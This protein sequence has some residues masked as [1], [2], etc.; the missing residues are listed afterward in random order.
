MRP[1]RRHHGHRGS[2]E[3]ADVRG[4]QGH[5][6]ADQRRRCAR[7]ARARGGRS[8]AGGGAAV[9]GSLGRSRSLGGTWGTRSA[10]P[11][12]GLR[13]PPPPP[14]PSPSPL[15]GPR[16]GPAPARRG[17]AYVPPITASASGPPGVCPR[18]RPWPDRVL[19]PAAAPADPRPSPHPFPVARLRSTISWRPS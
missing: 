3:A 19:S 18:C 2:G 14:R 8:P 13:L 17:P 11:P 12:P 9:P 1:S 5:R 10:G 6:R 16:P 4:R 7:W 15:P